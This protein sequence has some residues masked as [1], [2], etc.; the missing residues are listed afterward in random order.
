MAKTSD[1][2]AGPPKADKTGTPRESAPGFFAEENEFDRRSLLGIGTWGAVAV[3]AVVLAV[4]SNQSSLG[5]T[6]EQLPATDLARQAQQIQQV[7]KES[8]NETRRLASA[9]DTLNNDRDRLY[10]RVTVIEQGLDSLT[11]ALG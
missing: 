7:A 2:P 9:I 3:G 11:G 6:R 10:S 1:K 8:Q 4:I 5:W